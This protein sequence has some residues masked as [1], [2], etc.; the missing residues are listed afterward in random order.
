MMSKEMI[1]ILRNK[2]NIRKIQI[3]VLQEKEKVLIEQEKLILQSIERTENEIRK[4]EINS[5]REENST[6]TE[7]DPKEI[8]QDIL[9]SVPV[10]GTRV[11]S[12]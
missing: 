6:K 11:P 8:I 12:R 10:P 4:M 1:E 9:A 3:K 5:E 7:I 2:N